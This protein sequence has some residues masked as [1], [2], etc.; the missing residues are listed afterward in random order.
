MR[1]L[2]KLSHRL[3]FEE[4]NLANHVMAVAWNYLEDPARLNPFLSTR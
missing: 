1:L 3:N 4:K 2:I